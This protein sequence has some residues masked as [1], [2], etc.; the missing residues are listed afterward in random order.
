VDC[1]SPFRDIDRNDLAIFG[2]KDLV[3]EVHGHPG[4]WLPS[5]FAPRK[6]IL[7]RSNRRQ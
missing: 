4:A 6:G 7:S 1:D 5:P 2:S 3:A